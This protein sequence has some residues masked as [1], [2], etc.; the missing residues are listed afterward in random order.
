MNTVDCSKSRNCSTWNRESCST[1]A[2]TCSDCIK[3]YIGTSGHDNSLCVKFRGSRRLLVASSTAAIST[4]SARETETLAEG[5]APEHR[6]ATS[7]GR[8]GAN[9]ASNST[10][11]SDSAATTTIQPCTEDSDCI[12]G[13]CLTSDS[14]SDSQW[15]VCQQQHKTCPNACT[16]ELQGRCQVLTY[17]ITSRVK[18]AAY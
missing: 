18:R 15:G 10:V 13:V 12:S 11:S 5:S 7:E 3:G 2:N 4:S 17:A 9:S 16:S 14:Q 8:F 1:T 6:F